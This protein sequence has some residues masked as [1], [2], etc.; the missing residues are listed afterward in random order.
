M[1]VILDKNVPKKV[2]ST[3]TTPIYPEKVKFAQVIVIRRNKPR[4]I[5][6]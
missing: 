1:W 4:Q 2:I 6:S 3:Q 5:E